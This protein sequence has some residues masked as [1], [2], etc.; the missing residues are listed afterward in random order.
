MTVHWWAREGL[1]YRKGELHLGRQNLADLVRSAG[2]PTFVYDAARVAQNLERIHTA[3][4]RHAVEHEIFFAL[5]ANRYL[6]LVTFLKLNDQ[7]G[8]D[9]CSPNELRLGRQIGFREEQIIVDRE[10]SLIDRQV[11]EGTWSTYKL[12][13][14]FIG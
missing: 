5:K 2:T 6:P 4:D 10:V 13:I 7:C 9:V 12:P 1:D 11:I 3:L 14:H 8:L